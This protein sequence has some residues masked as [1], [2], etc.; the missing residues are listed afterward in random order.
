MQP[1]S[2]ASARTICYPTAVQFSIIDTILSKLVPTLNCVN[3]DRT[4]RA[5][6]VV[7]VR[8]CLPG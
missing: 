4:V 3:Y 2:Y 6:L 5:V 1:S 8:V 7:D